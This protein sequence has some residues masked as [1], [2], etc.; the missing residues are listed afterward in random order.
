MQSFF[1]FIYFHFNR[2]IRTGDVRQREV[3]RSSK[4]QTAIAS[5][6]FEDVEAPVGHVEKQE[7]DGEDEPRV[8]VDDV[9]V[10]DLRYDRLDG[11]NHQYC[12][13]FLP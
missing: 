12:E 9:H 10:L 3:K 13:T 5:L 2:T 4:R 1:H 11:C 6:D 7:R 8:L